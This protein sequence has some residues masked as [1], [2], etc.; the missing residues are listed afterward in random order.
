MISTLGQILMSSG[1]VD[2]E[3]CVASV[4]VIREA[5][6]SDHSAQDFTIS[7]EK[8]TNRKMN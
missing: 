1:K 7:E 5:M 8:W 4:V 6:R 2:R 3:K